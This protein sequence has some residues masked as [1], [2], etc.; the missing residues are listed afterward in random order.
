MTIYIMYNSCMKKSI[1]LSALLILVLSI[2]ILWWPLEGHI[3]NNVFELRRYHT[4]FQIEEKVIESV[5]TVFY[6]VI[7]CIVISITVICTMLIWIIVKEKDKYWKMLVIA[8]TGILA[9]MFVS[10]IVVWILIK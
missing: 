7:T 4:P 9:I 3:R 2:T 10:T 8:E 1:L 6:M 5:N